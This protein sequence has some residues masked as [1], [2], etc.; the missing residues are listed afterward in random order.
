[1]KVGDVPRHRTAQYNIARL[2][3]MLAVD[4]VDL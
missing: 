2:L 3:L 1:M 4:L